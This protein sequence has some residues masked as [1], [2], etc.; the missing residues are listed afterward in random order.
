[1]IFIKRNGK[2]LSASYSGLSRGFIDFLY[3]F[4]NYT[5]HTLT[6][7]FLEQALHVKN[8]DELTKGFKDQLAIHEN[9]VG[10]SSMIG[11]PLVIA[12]NLKINKC[13]RITLFFLTGRLKNRCF[14]AGISRKV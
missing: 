3:F 9:V 14:H 6:T 5:K 13:K 4:L 2:S 12:L 1:V 11:V 8:N 7:V 10:G